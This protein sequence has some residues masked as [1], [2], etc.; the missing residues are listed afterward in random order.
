MDNLVVLV[1]KQD[2]KI[3]TEEKIKAHLGKGKLHRAFMIIIF[4]KEKK[5][6]LLQKRSKNKMLWPLYW[7]CS[8]ASHPNL[9]ESHKKAGERRLK[10][11]LGFT[12]PLRN[13]GKFYYFSKYKNIGS[14]REICAFLIG[15]YKGKM[16]PNPEEVKDVMWIDADFLKKDILKNSDK[17]T[18]WLK[19]GI[20][21]FLK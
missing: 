6:I 18:P 4:D 2:K 21:K 11:E 10:E 16:N 19:I 15:D 12:T 8:C 17:Y 14:E 3:N 9:N 1:D 13:K 20:K 5:K 7:D